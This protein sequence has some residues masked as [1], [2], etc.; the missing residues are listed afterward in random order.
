MK[1]SKV[2]KFLD[3]ALATKESHD[4]ALNGLQVEGKEDVKKICMAV[5]AS[6]Q[7]IRLA[8]KKKADLLIVHH[9]LFWGHQK[10][11]SGLHGKRIKE[12][13]KY[14]MSL[15]A[16]HH[17]LDSQPS[18]GNNAVISKLLGVNTLTKFGNYKGDSWGF[19]G[20]IVKT[21]FDKF[22]KKLES[23]LRTKVHVLPFG[24]KEITKVGVVSGGGGFAV[25]E[26]A[27]LGLDVLVTGESSHK[28]YGESR[29]LGV[30][31]IFAGHY[32][33]E[34]FG[35]LGLEKL[36]EKKLALDCVFIA[37]PSGI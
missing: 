29:D 21:P 34:V 24:P 8:A 11:I 27:E 9:G 36:I 3:N 17:P 15:Y 12:L 4:F 14:D 25:E 7:T 35:L 23:V 33:T 37:A 13:I 18:F 19:R 5:D 26:A 32:H 20:T 1:L 30:N 28:A 10:A 22:V 31:V 6:L 2:V 16:S